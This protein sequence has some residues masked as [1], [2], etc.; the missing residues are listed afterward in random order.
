MGAH[1]ALR[2]PR[3]LAGFRKAVSW[4]GGN[5][6]KGAKK[7]NKRKVRGSKKREEEKGWGAPSNVM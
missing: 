3:P 5:E 7:G 2:L 6:R 1:S 4:Q